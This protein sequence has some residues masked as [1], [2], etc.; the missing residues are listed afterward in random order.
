M[1]I[2]LIEW[3][4]SGC[5]YDFLNLCVRLWKK[6]ITTKQNQTVQ[7]RHLGTA[8]KPRLPMWPAR[9]PDTSS[10]SLLCSRR[11][12]AVLHLRNPCFNKTWREEVEETEA[13]G[14]R[15]TFPKEARSANSYLQTKV[16][17][18]QNKKLCQV[19]E[20]TEFIREIPQ[21]SRRGIPNGTRAWC[22]SDKSEG[23]KWFPE[24]ETTNEKVPRF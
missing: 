5:K 24:N 6:S 19:E 11:A 1:N 10:A 17:R 15:F 21:K 20:D 23:P 9:S 13:P 16:T 2:L 8:H 14:N 7:L 3:D 4:C 18:S 22:P 12:L